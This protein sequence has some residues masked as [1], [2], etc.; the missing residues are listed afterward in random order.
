MRIQVDHGGQTRAVALSIERDDARVGDLA[1]ELG[2][3]ISTGIAVDGTVYLP[4]TMLADVALMDG[5]RVT[6]LVDGSA[7]R[8]A[9]GETWLGVL[10]GPSSGSIRT[11]DSVGNVL[12]G[13]DPNSGLPI[14]SANVSNTHALVERVSED[15]FTVAD[16]E[17]LNGTWV[18]GESISKETT[19][20]IEDSI[21]VGSSILTLRE[22]ARGDQPVGVSAQHAN[23]RGRVLFNRPPRTPIP[24]TPD[25][26][27]L[28]DQPAERLS[29]T[30]RIATLIVPLIFAGVMVMVL[31]DLRYALFGLLS[32]VMALAN[33]VGGRR[34]TK[35]EREGDVRT[36]REALVTLN[37]QLEKAVDAERARRNG[38][39]PDLLEVRRRIELPSTRLWERRLGDEDALH[40]R[41]GTGQ[42]EFSPATEKK[43]EIASDVE[44]ALAGH[45]TLDNVELVAGL[46]DG[47]L[48]VVG[49]VVLRTALVR[50]LMMQL[51]THHGPADLQVAILTT[52]ER[53]DQWSWAHW[54]PHSR[55]S[56]EASLILAGDAAAGFASSLKE[57]LEP[58]A[59]HGPSTA[60][61][62]GWLIIV[63]DV[64]LLHRRSSSVREL[65]ER[66][67]ANVHGIVLTGAKDQ[68]PA[69]T[70]SIAEVT[71]VDGE[72]TLSFT[73][74][75][76]YVEHG[77]ADLMS[78]DVA[79]GLARKLA[80]FEDPELPMPNGDLPR[81]V[82]AGDLHGAELTTD[83]LQRRWVVS[84]SGD[85]LKT[86]IGVGEQG[87]V[88]IDMVGDGPHALIGGTTGAGKS[89]LLRAFVLGLALNHDPD[90]LV[91]V[92]VDYKGGSAF[93]ACSNLPH[94][95]GLVTDLDAH[96]S[97]RA[98]LSLEAELH[99]REGVLR[100]VEAKD[101]SDYRSQGSPSGPLPRLVVVIDEFATLRAELPDFVAA[102]IGIAQRG[103]SLGVHL[104]LATQRPSGAVDAN[105]KA[106]TNLRIAL[107]MQD[108]PD[109]TDVIDDAAAA[110][111][112]RSTP[113]RAYIRTGQ[114]E[115]TV[116]QTGYVS[117][118]T[119]T[120]TPPLRIADV[121]IGSGASPEFPDATYEDE[122]S[123]LEQLVA[124]ITETPRNGPEPRRPWLPVLPE[125]VEREMLSDV[126]LDEPAGG[127]L[128]VKVA[129]ADDPEHQ[130][131]V[132]KTWNAEEGGLVI[133]GAL[134]SGVSTGLRGIIAALGVASPTRSV[135]VF[136]VDHA[137]G[138]LADIDRYP[139][140]SPVIAGSD[141]ERQGR[142]FAVLG[143]ALDT[144][145]ELSPDLVE[146]LPLMVVAVDGAA[147][148]ASSNDLSSGSATGDLWERIVRDGPSVG[149]VTVMGGSNRKEIPRSCWASASQRLMLEQSDPSDFSEIGI[150]AANV[151]SFVPGR[152]FWVA[153]KMFCQLINWPEIIDPQRCVVPEALPD[154]SPLETTIGRDVL[155]DVESLIE[156]DLVVPVGV[157]EL[158]RRIA[159]LTV[160]AGEHAVVSGPGGS[161]RTNALVLISTQLRAQFPELVMVGIAPTT[162]ADLFASGA[163]DAHGV[164]EGLESVLTA[165]QT[166]ERRWVIVVD[167][168]ERIEVESGPLLDLAKNAPPNVTFIAGLRSSTARQSYGHWSR[169]LRGSGNGVLLQ[170]DNS[171]DGELLGVRLPRHERLPEVPGRGY[172]VTGGEAH[173]VQLAR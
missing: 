3:D 83:D 68:L 54:L 93:D 78:I 103:R 9:V 102:L 117:G 46:S 18:D 72:V 45:R 108:G 32:P 164:V 120:N 166:D 94:V 79:N 84:A 39:A 14:S 104:V 134:G 80:R 157:D 67:D 149:I 47:P 73:A 151:P 106:N 21:R 8:S 6:S 137:A 131:R 152:G 16:L 71:S 167:D 12:V 139:H 158:T 60:L 90:D 110:K 17:S 114:G 33:W 74:S 29:P 124:L 58:K 23:S 37:K 116:V 50:S 145:R 130:R 52:E 34:T 88:A 26:I 24:A 5:S 70:S 27:L 129:L 56:Q 170:P 57:S 30:L 162:S 95:V 156:P 155:R 13:R 28:P 111:L 132:I 4:D 81:I 165:A 36:H 19:I 87:T 96:L 97:E 7:G 146:T 99:H 25:V 49:L 38:F 169:F 105:I 121:P 62:P 133:I 75:P 51:V 91:F 92:L 40:V 128:S 138:G 144:R 63:D 43:D 35:R 173:V 118:T 150:R 66:A 31:G 85:Q 122:T 113:G 1:R 171:V 61:R 168:A 141:E 115:L 89:E 142:L 64:E 2:L 148:F 65:L 48:G 161:G 109:S 147:G 119:S 55:T 107:R 11:L 153:D 123:E 112:S 77:I 20:E 100:A 127:R 172:L 143:Q 44:E 41:I 136:P 22:V 154:I 140:V 76:E 135:W 125:N 42:I 59:G 101:I 126:A 10:N 15:T 53:L 82:R 163:F 86:D 160:R 159:Q 69:S 98:L